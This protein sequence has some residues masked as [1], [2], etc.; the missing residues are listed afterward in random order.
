MA[1]RPLHGD[2]VLIL[3]VP[4]YYN[5]FRKHAPS[6]SQMKKEQRMAEIR[7]IYEE[8]HEIYG[9][10][11]IAA[12]MVQKGDKVSGSTVGK[13]MREMGIRACY[14]EHWVRTTRDCNFSSELKNILNRDFKP[15]RPDA[16]WCTDITYLYTKKDAWF[17]IY[18]SMCLYAVIL[19]L[20]CFVDYANCII[21]LCKSLTKSSDNS[22]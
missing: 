18:C 7:T 4:V 8:S 17:T 9:A 14:R 10:P 3:V 13:Y 19:I 15:P 12:K 22:V 20:N 21:S 11:K 16:A 1:C 5:T 6:A 2:V